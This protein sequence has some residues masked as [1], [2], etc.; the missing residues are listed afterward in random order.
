MTEKLRKAKPYMELVRT[1]VPIV[2]LAL[3][4]VML[5]KIM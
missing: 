4:L 1:L 3:Q 2:M 5:G